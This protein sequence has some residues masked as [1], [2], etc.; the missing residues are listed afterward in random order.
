MMSGPPVLF[1]ASALDRRGSTLLQRFYA[2][3][4]AGDRVVKKIKNL[5]GAADFLV[6]GKKASAAFLLIAASDTLLR[7]RRI[8]LLKQAQEVRASYLNSFLIFVDIGSTSTSQTARALCVLME[9]MP[10]DGS[11]PSLLCVDAADEEAAGAAL[12][13]VVDRITSRLAAADK[14]EQVKEALTA[15][16]L[17]STKTSL[18]S[19]FMSCMQKEEAS[20]AT[21]MLF[22]SNGSLANIS[23]ASSTLLQTTPLSQK[24][25]AA[26]NNLLKN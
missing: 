23:N 10:I 2:N 22:Q 25:V 5:L 1:A 11:V 9:S 15:S 13:R 12:K 8:K 16:H 7:H 26:I 6:S 17:A 3:V 4:S 19:A 18:E 14:K 20:M 21:S 24:V